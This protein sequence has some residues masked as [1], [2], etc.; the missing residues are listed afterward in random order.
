MSNDRC[1]EMQ[2][3]SATELTNFFQCGVMVDIGVPRC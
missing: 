3:E 1:L 2:A